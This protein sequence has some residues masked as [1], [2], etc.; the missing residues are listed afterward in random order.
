MP[1][2][3]AKNTPLARI[4]EFFGMDL[5]A[6]K[7]EWTQGNL[8]AEDKKQLTDGVVAF[9]DQIP[10]AGEREKFLNDPRAKKDNV[11]RY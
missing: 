9:Y 3:G 1:A 5:K 7:A 4:R 2:A 8:T 10:D 6:M 11:L